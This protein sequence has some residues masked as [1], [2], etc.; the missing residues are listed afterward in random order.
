M[1]PFPRDHATDE[2]YCG[3][4][5]S[6]DPTPSVEAWE[7]LGVTVCHDCGGELLAR[8]ADEDAALRRMP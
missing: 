2:S 4:C 6:P 7:V 3:E 1:T 5:G 8:E